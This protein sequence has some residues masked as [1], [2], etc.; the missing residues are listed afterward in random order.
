MKKSILSLLIAVTFTVLI[1]FHTLAQSETIEKSTTFNT[2]INRIDNF[3]GF[4]G[5]ILNFGSNHKDGY[6]LSGGG[7]AA[8][9]NKTYY[10]GGFGM[11]GVM[12]AIART[13]APLSID[14]NYGGFWLGYIYSKDMLIHPTGSIKMG[15]GNATLKN[16]NLSDNIFALMPQIGAEINVTKWVKV[17][18]GFSYQLINGINLIDIDASELRQPHIGLDFKFGWFK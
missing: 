13:D 1:N 7:G 10:I 17:E 6:V 3:S 15:W 2:L 11:S 14:I 8:L 9:L 16:S 5:V 12:N 4:G 18:L